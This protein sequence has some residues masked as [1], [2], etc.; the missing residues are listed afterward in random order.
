[1]QSVLAGSPCFLEGLELTSL[2]R[3]MR[4]LDSPGRTFIAPEVA[5]S[6]YARPC[7]HGP[8]EPLRHLS[9]NHED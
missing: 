5:M 4:I 9:A 7:K 1:M 8:F 6:L 3:V 2:S